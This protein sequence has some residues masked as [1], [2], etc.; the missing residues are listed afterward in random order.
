[1]NTRLVYLAEKAF[2]APL[3]HLFHK[4]VKILPSGVIMNTG[5]RAHH[6]NIRFGFTE[7]D[8]FILFQMFGMTGF[9]V[10]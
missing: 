9:V 6:L 1:M 3:L 7:E 5:K 8:V 4:L 10:P 2:K